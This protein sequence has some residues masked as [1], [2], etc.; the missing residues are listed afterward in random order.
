MFQ[1]PIVWMTFA[2]SAKCKKRAAVSKFLS[3]SYVGCN[4]LINYDIIILSST[5]HRPK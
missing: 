5:M 1:F 2:V 3:G 4:L